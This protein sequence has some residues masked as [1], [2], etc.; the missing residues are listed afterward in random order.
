MTETET[1]DRRT[2]RAD[3]AP[4]V[5][6]TGIDSHSALTS[7]EVDMPDPHA[8]HDCKWDTADA[9]PAGPNA[10][11]AT[12]GAPGQWGTDESGTPVFGGN[13]TVPPDLASIQGASAAWPV[14]GYPDPLMAWVSGEFVTLADGAETYW[15]GGGAGNGMWLEGRTP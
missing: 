14:N 3:P 7:P 15:A 13:V 11:C 8:H 5:F 4:E 12:A 9:A 1:P 6:G 10:N 2:A